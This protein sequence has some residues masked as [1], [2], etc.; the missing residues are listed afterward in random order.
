MQPLADILILYS[1]CCTKETF[2]HILFLSHI[3]FKWIIHQF[4]YFYQV[5]CIYL[6]QLPAGKD[7]KPEEFTSLLYSKVQQALAQPGESVGLLCSQV[8]NYCKLWSVCL[9][10]HLSFHPSCIRL[11]SFLKVFYHEVVGS[12]TWNLICMFILM[13]TSKVYIEIG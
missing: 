9:F 11:K 12:S 4:I 7:V 2:H 10:V 6:L 13:W 1:T 5:L 8:N 3:V